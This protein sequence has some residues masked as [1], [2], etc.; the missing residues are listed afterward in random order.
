M[1]GGV[2]QG[3]E[4]WLPG[5]LP[6]LCVRFHAW[7]LPVQWALPRRNC[8]KRLALLPAALASEPCGSHTPPCGLV[9]KQVLFMCTANVLDTIPGPLLDRMEVI[10]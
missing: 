2:K 1:W 10:R 4:G 3:Q 7:F 5:T 8:A 6:P 9:C